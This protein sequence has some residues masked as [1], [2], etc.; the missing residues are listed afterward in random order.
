MSSKNYVAGVK[1]YQETYWCPDHVPNDTD[2]LACFKIV[3]QPGV[4]RE[5]AAAAVAAETSPSLAR[6]SGSGSGSLR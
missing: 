3:A 4:P 6:R 1:A 2:L 5:E